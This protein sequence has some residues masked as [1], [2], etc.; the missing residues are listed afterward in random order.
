MEKTSSEQVD[1]D[2]KTDKRL[3]DAEA[4]VTVLEIRV[5]IMERDHD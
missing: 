5:D 1:K 2:D 3:S 4:R